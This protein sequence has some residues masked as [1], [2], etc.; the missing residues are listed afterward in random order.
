MSTPDL[1]DCVG[2][3]P[4][5]RDIVGAG[6]SSATSAWASSGS[7]RAR[8]QRSSSKRG[9]FTSTLSGRTAAWTTW[10]RSSSSSSITPSPT[11]PS[12]KN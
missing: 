6:H 5:Q 8:R 7:A 9:A 11:E 4:P 12:S 10:R 2:N 1:L 3:Q